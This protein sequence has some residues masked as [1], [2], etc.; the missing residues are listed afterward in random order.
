MQIPRILMASA[1]VAALTLGASCGG[2]RNAASAPTPDASSPRGAEVPSSPAGPTAAETSTPPTGSLPAPPPPAPQ[3]FPADTRPDTGPPGGPG[4]TSV[5]D[6]EVARHVGFDRLVFH[7]SGDGS[8][9]WNVRYVQAAHSQGSGEPVEVRGSAVLEVT[10]TNIGYPDDVAGPRY[11]GPRRIRPADTEAIREIV[12]DNVYEGRHVFFV[13]TVRQLPFRVFRLD[14]PQR[15][16][17][18]IQHPR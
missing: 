16:V 5:S 14:G 10:L 11:E 1:V 9:G 17:L 13:G 12:N 18:D 8:A 7:I 3:P 2:G 4:P 15:V 6:V